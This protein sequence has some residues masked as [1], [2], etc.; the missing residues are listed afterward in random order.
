VKAL[1][2]P[3]SDAPKPENPAILFDLDGTLIDTAYEHVL[4]WSAALNSAGMAMPNWKIHRRIGMSGKSLIHQLVREH[5]YSA[6]RLRMEQLEK[7]HDVEFAKALDRVRPLPGAMKLIRTLSRLRVPCA[8]A[9]TGNRKQTRKLLRMLP[10]PSAV[11][12]VTGDDVLK[13]KPSPDVFIAAA[14]RLNVLIENCIVV[15]DSVWDMLA[16][17]RRRALA[18]GLLSGGYSQGELEQSG[19][20]RVYADPADML[21]HIED[22]GLGQS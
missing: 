10:L 4:A 1:K 5:G 15:G 17:G 6:R 11:V 9:T 12:T 22:I 13:A 2:Q 16:A 21:D 14:N 19:A 3:E 8:I 18:V 7:R 20:F